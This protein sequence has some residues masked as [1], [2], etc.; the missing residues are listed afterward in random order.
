MSP[1]QLFY[2]ENKTKLLERSQQYFLEKNAHI[3][4]SEWTYYHDPVVRP[5]KGK[6]ETPKT[7]IQPKYDIS[8][9]CVGHLWDFTSK[10]RGY[11][12]PAEALEEIPFVHGEMPSVEMFVKLLSQEQ[13]IDVKVGVV[14]QSVFS[15]GFG[16]CT[17]IE[18]LI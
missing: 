14:V 2:K 16:C 12:E 1:A 4:D 17:S 5:T 6:L 8:P 15:T 10:E 3:D 18:V 9:F 13:A 7:K 11:E